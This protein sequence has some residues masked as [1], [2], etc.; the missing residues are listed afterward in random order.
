[1]MWDLKSGDAAI[2]GSREY[3]D[4]R[5]QLVTEDE[6]ASMMGAYWQEAGIPT[7]A[8]QF[9]SERRQWL[10]SI[11]Q[12][13][14]RSFPENDALRIENGEPILGSLRQTSKIVR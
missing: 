6:V 8:Q 4:Y 12:E 1:M 10:A 7:D 9:V 2:E 13:T 11:A 14:D 5:E 3:A